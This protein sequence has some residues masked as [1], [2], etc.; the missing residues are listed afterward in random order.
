MGKLRFL[1]ALWIAKCGRL[2][3]RLL[4]RNA[5]Y[6]PGVVA[7]KLC[8]DFL[9]RVGK[10][11]KIVAVTGSNGKTTVSNLINDILISNG[12]RVLNNRLGSNVAAGIATSLLIGCGLL[13]KA[14]YE[15]ADRKSVV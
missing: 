14:K 8:P 1:L 2:A 13:G 4:R 9:T 7:L 15:M 10:P 11:D 3:L 6:F 5:T 12:R